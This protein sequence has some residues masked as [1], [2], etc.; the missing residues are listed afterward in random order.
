MDRFRTYGNPPFETILLH[1]GPGAPGEMA[2]VARVLSETR[3]VIEHLQ[4]SNS[5]DGQVLELSE[6]IEGQLKTPC[7]IVGWSWG[8]WLGI[9]FTAGYRELVRKLILV[10]CGPLE[11]KYA[12]KMLETRLERLDPGGRRDLMLTLGAMNDPS[13]GD[14]NDLLEH[15]GSLVSLTDSFEALPHEDQV[16]EY[17]FDIFDRVSGEAGK[18]RRSGELLQLCGLIECP[19]TVIHGEHDPHP[20]QGVKEP[21]SGVLPDVRFHLLERCGHCPWYEK[22]AGDEFFTILEKEIP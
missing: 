16:L 4:S 21:L 13:K 14:R 2:P 3:G 17:S 18:M 12:L 9:I 8:A 1:G 15:L 7:T 11:E 20:F 5:I 19:V 10:G 6:I 22:N